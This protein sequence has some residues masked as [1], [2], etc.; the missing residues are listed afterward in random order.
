[1]SSTDLSTVVPGIGNYTTRDL[2]LFV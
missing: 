1:V 2:G